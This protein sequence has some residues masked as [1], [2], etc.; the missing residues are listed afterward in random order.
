[1]TA[2][3]RAAIVAAA[4][5]EIGPQQK[6]SHEV[7]GYWREVLPRTWTDAQVKQ[8]AATKHWCGGFALWCLHQAGVAKDVTWRDGLGFCEVEHLPRTKSPQP[9]DIAYTDQPFQHHAIVHS[10][11][12][13]ILVTIDG[14]QPDCRKRTRPLPTSGIH[15]YSIEPFL[16]GDSDDA[17]G[18]RATLRKGSKGQDVK[19]L[20]RLLGGLA[21]DGDFGPKTEA[22]AK[23]FQ[24]ANGLA[25]DGIVGPKTWA[26]LEG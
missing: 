17:A 1:M 6:G 7:F 3:I 26:A 11:D 16:L 9:G 8:Y 22:A 24:S 18:S 21:V 5:A 12:G 14:N 4:E 20:Q 23:A 2:V 15:F 13:G 25:V 10:L 19:E